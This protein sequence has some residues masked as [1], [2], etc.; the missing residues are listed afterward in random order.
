[1]IIEVANLKIEIKNR[2]DYLLTQCRDYLS[3][4][5]PDFSVEASEADISRE[6][7]ISEIEMSDGY[8]ESL[9][10]Y[11]EIGKRLPLYN[12]VI[13]HAAAI[14][15]DDKAY[16][17]LAKSGTGKSTHIKLLRRLLGDRVSAINGDKPI[18]RLFDGVPYACGTPWQGKENWGENKCV[19]IKAL[20]FVHRGEQNKIEEISPHE[21]VPQL[22]HQVF[23]PKTLDAMEKTLDITDS[24][25]NNTKQYKLFCTPD[26]EAAKVSFSKM[27]E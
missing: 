1:M 4:G 26:I 6:R 25:L 20:C 8:Y 23:M 21:A 3:D 16:L 19:P 12:A 5:V 27:G 18:V 9:C 24:V 15:I 10:V 2:H 13:M 17:F 11:R 22:M 14:Q 7:E